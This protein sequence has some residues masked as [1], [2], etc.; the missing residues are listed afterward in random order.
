VLLVD[1][2]PAAVAAW[3]KTWHD[4]Q[5]LKRLFAWA[6]DEARLFAIN[7]LTKVKHPPKGER[8]RILTRVEI[9]RMLRASSPDCRRL[10]T[11]YRETLARP[12][13]LRVAGWEDIQPIDPMQPLRAA[14]RT[15]Q[16]CIVLHDFKNRANR[17]DPQTPRVILLSP[18][19][20]RLLLRLHDR[21]LTRSGPIFITRRGRA[22]TSN[23]LRCR[24]RALRKKLDIRRDKR[25]ET[26]VPY[27]FRHTGATIAAACGVRDRI[28]ADVLGHI[29][30]KT[31]A[32]YQHLQRQHLVQA[33][34]AVWNPAKR[35]LQGTPG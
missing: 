34:G 20:C 32:R 22:W 24:F 19:V 12:Q 25:G 28:L 11:G 16:C 10:L 7:P 17:R 30:T 29:E 26:I 27:T 9:V 21:S 8:K 18:R 33:M 23:A 6:V 1:V 13:E 35:T 14:L 3:G 2:T 5:S 15:A 4:V 31:T